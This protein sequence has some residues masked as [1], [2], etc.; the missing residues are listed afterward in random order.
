MPGPLRK[1]RGRASGR[2]VAFNR[3]LRSR[4]LSGAE[5]LSQNVSRANVWIVGEVRIKIRQENPGYIR[6][7]ARRRNL[8][9]PKG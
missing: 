2:D 9:Q 5:S 3:R 4:N 1:R 6:R 8:G 7:T